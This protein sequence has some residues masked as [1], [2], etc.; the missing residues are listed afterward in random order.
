M[1]T[2]GRK[3]NLYSVLDELAIVRSRFVMIHFVANLEN[4]ITLRKLLLLK[5]HHTAVIIK[6]HYSFRY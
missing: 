4:G 5:Q 3:L 2:R 6:L 1:K